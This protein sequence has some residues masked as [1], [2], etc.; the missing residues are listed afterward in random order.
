[1]NTFMD[2]NSQL[3]IELLKYEWYLSYCRYGILVSVPSTMSKIMFRKSV[4]V[5]SIIY[6]VSM[7]LMMDSLRC[8][9]VKTRLTKYVNKLKQTYNKHINHSVI[10]C[11]T[12]LTQDQVD[13]RTSMIPSTVWHDDTT[14]NPDTQY[15][16]IHVTTCNASEVP[17]PLH[18]T[19]RDHLGQMDPDDLSFTLHCGHKSKPFALTQNKLKIMLQRKSVV[20]NGTKMTVEYLHQHTPI[21]TLSKKS[22]HLI[23]HPIAYGHIDKHQYLRTVYKMNVARFYE[24]V[25]LNIVMTSI[26]VWYHLDVIK[27]H[28]ELVYFFNQPPILVNPDCLSCTETTWVHTVV[29]Y[30]APVMVSALL[31]VALF[32]YDCVG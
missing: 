11:S 21:T 15:S 14:T 9:R 23:K 1:M 26:A 20:V 5:D 28:L 6:V 13:Q 25:F 27:I 16:Y 18:Q 17:L 32:L 12:T 24:H 29:Y 7:V 4:L 31:H 19:R 2:V 22:H 8:F 30:T 10:V 3:E